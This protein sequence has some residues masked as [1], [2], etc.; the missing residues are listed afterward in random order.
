M[1]RHVP[2]SPPETYHRPLVA[3]PPYH[4]R[5][6][7]PVVPQMHHIYNGLSP[8]VAQHPHQRLK[9]PFPYKVKGPCPTMSDPTVP[10]APVAHPPAAPPILPEHTVQPTLPATTVAP[11]TTS[12][13]VVV[14]T[15]PPVETTAPVKPLVSTQSGLITT[16]SP[17]ETGRLLPVRFAFQTKSSMLSRSDL[18]LTFWDKKRNNTWSRWCLN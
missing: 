10:R 16:V 6:K 8:P 18:F 12:L 13:P 5:F 11:V 2:L 4:N 14:T 1:Y 3:M 7:G 9:G 15:V 17:V